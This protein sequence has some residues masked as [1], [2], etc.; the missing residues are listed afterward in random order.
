MLA[1][2]GGVAL[3]LGVLTFMLFRSSP[4]SAVAE[5]GES[6][7]R[8]VAAKRSRSL[9][10]F[11][12]PQSATEPQAPPSFQPPPP[13]FI[14]PEIAELK[15]RA[16]KDGY[17]YREA[18]SPDV[19]V[20]QGGTKY[21]IKSP[22]EFEALGYKWDQVEE[23]PRGSLGHLNSR[24]AERTLL[25]ERD[26]QA[27]FMYE[28]GQKRFIMPGVFEKMGLDWKDVKVVP[29]GGLGNETPGAAIR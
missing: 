7:S 13:T 27:V 12:T 21:F 18:G 28:N 8:A 3:G 1:V 11:N 4:G 15:E 16:S 6:G 25:R 5:S 19:F 2:A 29:A 20:V 17:L 24:P 9:P 22:Q 23:V 14:K 26:S 10:R